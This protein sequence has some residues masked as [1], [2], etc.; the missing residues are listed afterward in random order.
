MT[1]TEFAGHI[2]I[3]QKQLSF[4]LNRQASMII[5]VAHQIKPATSLKAHWRLE[6]Y[7]NIDLQTINQNSNP[8]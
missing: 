8:Q 7:L 5:S 3:S 2:A 6:L 1:Q 4:I